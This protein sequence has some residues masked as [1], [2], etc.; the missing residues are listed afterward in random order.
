MIAA[1]LKALARPAAL[2]VNGCRGFFEEDAA[3]L[4]LAIGATYYVPNDAIFDQRRQRLAVVHVGG[5]K[6]FNN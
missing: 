6:M 3:P 5:D 4:R 2:R 1:E